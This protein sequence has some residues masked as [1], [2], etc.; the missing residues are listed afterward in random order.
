MNIRTSTSTADP[1]KDPVELNGFRH[2]TEQLIANLDSNNLDEVF[3]CISDINQINNQSIFNIV[4]KITRELH[5]AIADLS[6]PQDNRESSKNR[7]RA[8]LN[9]VIEVTDNA[10][11]S[12]LDMTEKAR[13][14][15]TALNAGF[16]SQDKLTQALH[17]ERDPALQA[18]LLRELGTQT[19]ANRALAGA[20][21]GNVTEIVL[22]QNFQDLASQSISK[23]L[24]IINDV[25]SS[26]VSLIHYTNILRQ[27]ARYSGSNQ[28]PDQDAAR[29][30]R[31]NLEHIESVSESEHMDQN[32]VDNLLSSLGF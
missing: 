12:T 10:A 27:L 9:Y 17:T 31:S 26:L 5:N 2:V 15:L 18:S 11:L 28:V 29:E 24:K 25:E 3:R 32:E 6:I 23:A 7:T 1:C 4:G 16:D 20:I 13:E 30:L 14:S 8:G 19:A 22:A 21:G